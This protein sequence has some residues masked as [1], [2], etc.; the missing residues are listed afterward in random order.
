MQLINNKQADRLYILPLL[1]A[2]RQHVPLLRRAHN[3]VALDTQ[4]H[5]AA[6]LTI[7]LDCAVFYVPSNTV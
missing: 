7:G 1:P 4:T 5:T 3:Y 6:S 2:S